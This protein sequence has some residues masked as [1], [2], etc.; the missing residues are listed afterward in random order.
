MVAGPLRG[1]RIATLSG[2]TSACSRLAACRA[3]RRREWVAVE[4]DPPTLSAARRRVLQF[5]R[6][7][8]HRLS[9]ALRGP[10]LFGRLVLLL[11][12]WAHAASGKEVHGHTRAVVNASR[13]QA[14]A[15]KERPTRG[16]RLE[17]EA[18][19]A[20]EAIRASENR[21]ETAAEVL[22][23][24]RA[25]VHADFDSKTAAKLDNHRRVTR[26]ARDSDWSSA[27]P[28]LQPRSGTTLA[29]FVRRSLLHSWHR[30]SAKSAC[31]GRRILPGAA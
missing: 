11:L 30:R 24:I 28:A 20:T 10:A 26:E 1:A 6:R 8:R 27:I 16:D 13:V 18:R 22:H 15:G 9:R 4:R 23:G 5:G 29:H 2:L 7:L 12:P 17:S 31:D 25:S 19:N 3:W 14:L 21:R